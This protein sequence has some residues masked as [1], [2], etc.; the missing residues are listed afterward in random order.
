MRKSIYL[1]FIISVTLLLG[2]GSKDASSS[3]IQDKKS[4]GDVIINEK[5]TSA[6]ISDY[7][8]LKENVR[9]VYAGEG[10]EYASSNLYVDFIKDSKIQYRVV[11]GGTTSGQVFEIKNGELRMLDSIEEFYYRDDLT[12]EQ[13]QMVDILLKEPLTKGN[14]WLSASGK[15]RYIASLDTEVTVPY[16]SFKTIEVV[17]DN[18]DSKVYDFYAKGVGVVKRIFNYKNNKVTVNLE[19]ILKDVKVDQTVKFYYPEYNKNLIVYRKV[20]LSLKTNEQVKNY[21]E[22]YFKEK[23]TADASAVISKKTKINKLYLNREENK[24]YVD[25]SKDLIKDMNLGS[26][27]E[28]MMLQAI[29]NTLGD[30][31]NVD[32]VRIT[33]EGKNYESGHV[34]IDEKNPLM[35]N[36]K[37]TVEIK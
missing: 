16:G 1:I 15:K 4:N 36:I 37:N 32:K 21:F 34:I 5:S 13:G 14:S 30:Y 8:P 29:T 10:M 18:G 3:D 33:V 17:T 12:A 19:K 22:K 31:Y 35:V 28:T 26:G 11:N 24:V 27:P 25:F 7:Y 23:P 9:Y 2:C 6:S 20:K